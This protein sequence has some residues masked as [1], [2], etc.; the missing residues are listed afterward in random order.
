MTFECPLYQGAVVPLDQCI[1]CK[2]RYI[3]NLSIH[4]RMRH[5]GLAVDLH[6]RRRRLEIPD[7]QDTPEE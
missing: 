7:P 5:G 2:R 6:E 3:K 4:I 1:Y